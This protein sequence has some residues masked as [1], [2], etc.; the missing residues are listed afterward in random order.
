MLAAS[1]VAMTN[2][3]GVGPCFRM[4]PATANAVENRGKHLE[5]VCGSPKTWNELT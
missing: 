4:S 5:T 1:T 3:S 2:G